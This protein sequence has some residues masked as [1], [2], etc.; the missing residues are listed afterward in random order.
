M[1]MK[2]S[3]RTVFSIALAAL[4]LGQPGFAPGAQA[5]KHLTIGLSF[6][7]LSFAWFA[8]LEKAV[9]DKARIV[10]DVDVLSVESQNQVSKQ[11][12]DVE[13]M[14]VKKVAGVLLVPIETK[15]V[16]P[17]VKGLNKANIPVV[18]VDRRLEESAGVQ[19]LGHV[20][21][22]NVQGGRIAARYVADQLKKKFGAVRGTVIELYG[23]PGAGPAI[24]RSKG[25]HDVLEAY[26]SVTIKQYTANFAREDG[27]KVMEDVITG[28]GKFDAVFGAN[29]EMILGGLEAIKGSGK[30]NPQ[31]I[32]TIGFDALPDALR[33]IKDGTLGATIEQFPGK[34]AAT[35]FEELVTFLRSGQKPAKHVLLITPRLIT[36]ANLTQAEKSF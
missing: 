14:I 7:S 9:K 6:P 8:F 32:I 29:D 28:V 23:S 34:Q 20:G 21:A 10:G 27:L 13:D 12:S 30:M 5:A 19:I 35:G 25:F 36:K 15:A 4:L 24:D 2:R 3:L 18:T 17:A 11:V 22:D 16:I 33:A 31:D 1:R 26:K